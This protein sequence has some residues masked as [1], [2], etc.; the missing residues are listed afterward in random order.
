MFLKTTGDE[1][2][3]VAQKI[4]MSFKTNLMLLLQGLFTAL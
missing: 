3:S 4:Y 1:L 2:E